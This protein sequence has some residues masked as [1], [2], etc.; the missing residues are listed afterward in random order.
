[1]CDRHTPVV[2]RPRLLVYYDSK[3]AGAM[4]E[5]FGFNPLNNVFAT[6]TAVTRNEGL[7]NSTN[8]SAY[9]SNSSDYPP[10]VPASWFTVDPR[11]YRYPPALRREYASYQSDVLP[12]PPPLAERKVIEETIKKA[13][14]SR[15]GDWESCASELVAYELSPVVHAALKKAQQAGIRSALVITGDTE[16][17]VLTTCEEYIQWC[18]PSLGVESLDELG[19]IVSDSRPGLSLDMH[20]GRCIF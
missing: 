2:S 14:S 12:P 11:D 1:M 17:Q 7:Y 9:M 5:G 6:A 4:A 16:K 20:F 15:G 18:W 10:R 8:A 13:A 19:K 3:A